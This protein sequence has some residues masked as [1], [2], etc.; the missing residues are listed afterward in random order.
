MISQPSVFVLVSWKRA[1]ISSRA[2]SSISFWP[3]CRLI[4]AMEYLPHRFPQRQLFRTVPL[5]RT[6]YVQVQVV[7]KGAKLVFTDLKASLDPKDA[8]FTNTAA[9][10]FALL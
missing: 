3:S 10:V 6:L 2:G 4:S 5:E 1:I 7:K 8:S 9:S